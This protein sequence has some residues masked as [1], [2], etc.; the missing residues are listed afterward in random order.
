MVGWLP[1]TEREDERSLKIASLCVMPRGS[2][3]DRDRE[4]PL[5]SCEAREDAGSSEELLMHREDPGAPPA[6]NMKVRRRPRYEE[7]E[8]VAPSSDIP[9]LSG[10]K[11]TVA[12]FDRGSEGSDGARTLADPGFPTVIL[13]GRNSCP[14]ERRVNVKRRNSYLCRP[15]RWARGERC[16]CRTQRG[17]IVHKTPGTRGRGTI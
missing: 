11:K 12:F 16:D 2:E 14:N 15:E 4:E 3:H 1:S 10:V 7:T 9:R 5:P 13:T 8:T 6:G 17:R